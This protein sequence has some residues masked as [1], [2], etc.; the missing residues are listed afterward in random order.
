VRFHINRALHDLFGTK[1]IVEES[2]D[3]KEFVDSV[4]KGKIL[5]RGKDVSLKPTRFP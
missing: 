4:N 1:S 2:I 5:Y 3:V